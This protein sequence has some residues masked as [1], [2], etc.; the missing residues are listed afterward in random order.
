MWISEAVHLESHGIGSYDT[1]CMLH[2]LPVKFGPKFTCSCVHV[3]QQ[4]VTFWH[5]WLPQIFVS[6]QSQF[7]FIGCQP[8][9][10]CL[11]FLALSDSW[12]L[13]GEWFETGVRYLQWLGDYFGR[14][15]MV[16]IPATQDWGPATRT[17]KLKTPA[18]ISRHFR[19]SLMNA[20]HNLSP[21][22]VAQWDAG[23]NFHS[24]Q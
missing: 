16:Q 9:T 4:T 20:L 2:G 5:L 12:K 22:V 11:T 8:L 14:K 17:R 23:I 24:K 1:F 15:F 21:A 7:S 13:N 18:N 19:N 10:S 3:L 6:N